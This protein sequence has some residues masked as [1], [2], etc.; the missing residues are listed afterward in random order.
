M[1][2]SCVEYDHLRAECCGDQCR[3]AAGNAATQ[4]DHATALGG[5]YTTQQDAFAALR[6]MQQRRG[7]LHR[8]TPRNVTHRRQQR[9][10]SI[11]VFDGLEGDRRQANLAKASRQIRQRGQMQI[12]KQQMVAPQPRQVRV[13]RLLH[14]DDHLAALEE[15]IRRRRDLHPNVAVLLIAVTALLARALLEPQFV[16]VAYQLDAS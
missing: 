11:T 9:Q 8:Q 16:S 1:S 12:A 14:L 7:V 10:S 6:L 2:R 15:L 4:H 13:D 5:R 3:I